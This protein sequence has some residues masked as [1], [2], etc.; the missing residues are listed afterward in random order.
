MRH[1][2][3]PRSRSQGPRGPGQASETTAKLV[4]DWAPGTALIVFRYG[5]RHHGIYVG[6]GRVIHYA[7]LIRHRRG[8]IEEVSLEEF[9]GDRRI[10]VGT[11]P[12]EIRGRDIV[13]RARSRLGECRYDLLRNNCEH[14][15]NWCSHGESRSDQ[16]DSLIGPIRALAHLASNLLVLFP[17]WSP[18]RASVRG[19]PS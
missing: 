1:R 12:D 14:F 7:G 2:T 6:N 18:S 5:Y 19:V 3:P 11:A 9:I 10:H 4:S 17:T 15:C 8:C 13:V 16:I